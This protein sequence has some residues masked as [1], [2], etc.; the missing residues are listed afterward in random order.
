MNLRVPDMS[1]GHCVATVSTAI[2]SVAPGAKVEVDLQTKLVRIDGAS[3]T[4]AVR[5]AIEASGYE[6]AGEAP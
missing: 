3:D 1:C 2:R 5:R 4:A 6:V